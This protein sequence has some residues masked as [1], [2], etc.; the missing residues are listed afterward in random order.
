MKIL[1]FTPYGARNGAEMMLSYLIKNISP[2]KYQSEIFL[3]AKGDL[4]AELPGVPLHFDKREEHLFYK[5]KDRIL[6]SAGKSLL[7]QQVMKIH[8]AF[9]PDVWYLNTLH[10]PR[11]SFLARKFRIPYIVHFHDMLLQY[12]KLKYQ[13]LKEMVEYAELLVGCSEVV[14]EKLKI[15]GASRVALQYECIDINKIKA[16]G[17]N[18]VLLRSK[19]GIPEGKFVWVMSGTINY[20]KGVD[21]I[22]KI[23]KKIG[24]A[25]FILWVG[26]NKTGL[27]YFIEKEIESLG[28]KNVRFV[29]SK[30]QDY[31][32]Y[33]SIADGFLLTSREDPFPLVMIEGAALG[34]PIVAF[35]SGGV[36]EFVKDEMGIVINSFD[37]DELVEAMI[38]VQNG[39]VKVDIEKL[40]NR[41]AEFDVLEQVKSWERMMAAAF[42]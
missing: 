4:V 30:V 18:A 40:K 5:I 41:A 25:A 12:E 23:A 27:K 16:S 28:L 13:E 38:R 1:F 22:P 39:D 21:L 14:C 15:M 31:Y 11:I 9:K 3:G 33:L 10:M 7:E 24:N 32:D 6:R 29:G 8:K 37:T 34:K 20:R 17:N 26:D 36:A 42:K 19:L 35:N 2:A